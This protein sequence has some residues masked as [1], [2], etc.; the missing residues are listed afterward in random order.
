MVTGVV[1][2]NVPSMYTAPPV[3]IE[4]TVR[5]PVPVGTVAGTMVGTVVG[6]V[7]GTL[8]IEGLKLLLIQINPVSPYFE[9]HKSSEVNIHQPPLYRLGSFQT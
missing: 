6:N 4:V 8:M 3:G 9:L 2:F 7:V 1:P 5:V